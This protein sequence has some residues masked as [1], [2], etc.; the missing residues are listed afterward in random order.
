MRVRN[1]F[2]LMKRHLPGGKIVYYYWIYDESNR[3]VYRS[4]GERTKARA[5]DYV[6]SLRDS[7]N[8]GGRDRAMILLR[9]FTRDFFI[10]GKCPIERNAHMRGKSMTKSTLNTRNIAL[11]LHI[12]PHLG[13]Y[14]VSGITKRTVN[15]WLMELP[16]K[17]KISR[18]TANGALEALRLVMEQAV[19][20]NLIPSNPCDKVENLGSD[21]KRRKAFTLEEVKAIIG[22][23]G[24]WK[25]PMIR[26]MCLTA[27]LT[28]MRVG[29]VKAILPECIMDDHILVRASFSHED[30]YKKPK[31]GKERTAP[32]P[33][34]LRD[35]LRSF[36]PADGGYI[37]TV[38]G[39]R[40]V[41]SNYV[42][43]CLEKRME[44]LGLTERKTFHGFRGFFNT[45]MEAA[46]INETV[47]RAVMGHSSAAMTKHYLHI[48]SAQFEK[49]QDRQKEILSQILLTDGK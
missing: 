17:D 42:S 28:G 37:F 43:L 34:T 16:G 14:P 8:L 21:S 18:T 30:G 4:T 24:D 45:Q 9:D 46:N 7:G 29:E 27:A 15:R 22:K 6:L 44:D 1:E 12:L 33:A 10:P 19:R 41:S 2:G 23:P 25:N 11:R 3:R 26:L 49:M 13:S 31:N 47:I 38:T 32:I 48:G 20:Q 5:L 36:C 39:D 35:E 40:P